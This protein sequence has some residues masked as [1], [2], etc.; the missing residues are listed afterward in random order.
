[1]SLQGELIRQHV[2]LDRMLGLRTFEE[3]GSASEDAPDRPQ[4]DL[5]RFLMLAFIPLVVVTLFIIAAT[6]ALT[7]G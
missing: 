5:S 3:P 7:N 2:R 1:M 6:G 4:S